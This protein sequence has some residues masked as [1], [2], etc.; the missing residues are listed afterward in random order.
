MNILSRLRLRTKL[1][2]LLGLSVLTLVAVIV[3]AASLVRQRMVEERIDKD[4]AIVQATI[5]IAQALEHRVAARQLTREQALSMLRD[6]IHAMR[7]DAGAGYVYAQTMDNT[8]VL[9]GASPALEGRPS[10]ATDADGRLVTELI[11]DV[12]RDADDGV[13]SYT[14][15]RPGQT[16]RQPKVSYVARF[17]PWNLVFVSGAYLEDLDVAFRAAMLRLGSISGMLTVALLL[18]AWL[19]NRDISGSLGRLNRA[20]LFLLHQPI[21]K[22]RINT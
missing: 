4:R 17:A 22:T 3:V 19:I 7:F 14:F 15:P 18:A 20:S 12:L 9:H 16:Q 21:E 13:V 11:R 6:D 1:A 2:L 5:G 10:P 8:I